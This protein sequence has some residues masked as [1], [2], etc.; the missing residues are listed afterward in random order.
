METAAVSEQRLKFADQFAAI[1]QEHARSHSDQNLQAFDL[2]SGLLRST[3]CLL[4]RRRG[5]G[6]LLKANLPRQ[7]PVDTAQSKKL[8]RLE[9]SDIYFLY[10]Q[11]KV[12]KRV[13][14]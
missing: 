11:M 3:H 1:A 5:R 2:V 8:D 13:C 10:I 6:W 4:S 9:L 7:R 12:L 14:I